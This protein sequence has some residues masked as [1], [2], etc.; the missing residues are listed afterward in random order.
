MDYM[1]V[2]VGTAN[3]GNERAMGRHDYGV[4]NDYGERLVGFCDMNNL[5]IEGT[6]FLHMDIHKISWNSPI[7]CDKSQID[8]LLINGKWRRSLLLPWFK[9]SSCALEEPH[10]PKGSLMFPSSGK[11]RREQFCLELSKRFKT[12]VRLTSSRMGQ[13]RQNLG[14]CHVNNWI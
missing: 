3:M 4:L 11:R 1:N 8:H 2:M 9:W 13:D 10:V 12:L 14:C 6:L 5:V 7:R